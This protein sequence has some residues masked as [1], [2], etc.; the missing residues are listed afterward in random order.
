[1]KIKKSMRTL[2]LVILTISVIGC[3]TTGQKSQENRLMDFNSTLGE[4]K[5]AA[6]DEAIDS[7]DEFLQVNFPNEKTYQDRAFSFLLELDSACK[8]GIALALDTS[9]S[10]N[11]ENHQRVFDLFENSGLRREI[12]LFG[13]EEYYPK[14]DL[15]ELLDSNI[16][17]SSPDTF[18]PATIQSDSQLMEEAAY[19]SKREG[20]N[21]DT[22]LKSL[23]FKRER[24]INSLYNNQFGDYIYGLIKHSG[25]SSWTKGFAMEQMQ[26]S[27]SPCVLVPSLIEFNETKVDLSDPFIKCIVAIELYVPMIYNDMLRKK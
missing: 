23:K 27:V 14:N 22:L 10:L 6:L 18:S 21:Y 26:M 7:F 12:W 9:W 2:S 17:Y 15:S 19:F 3:S 5:A 20:Y 4:Q 8:D 13:Y 24:S 16:F 1:M 11:P 25:D